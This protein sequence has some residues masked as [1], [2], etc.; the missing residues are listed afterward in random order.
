ME[1]QV[2]NHVQSTWKI[3]EGIAPQ[4]KAAWTE[5]YGIM[6]SVMISAGK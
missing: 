5:V 2:I 4:V 6:S 3:V 1:E